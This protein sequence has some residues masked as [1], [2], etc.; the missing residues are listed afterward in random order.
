V[1]FAARE[2][3]RQ[4][5]NRDRVIR[6]PLALFCRFLRRLQQFQKKTDKKTQVEEL[7]MRKVNPS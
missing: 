5:A 6:Q 7:G 3:L 4:V 1:K 2:I